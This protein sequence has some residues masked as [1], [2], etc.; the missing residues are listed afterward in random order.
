V[1]CTC[2]HVSLH[3]STVFSTPRHEHCRYITRNKK[4]NGR[5]ELTRTVGCTK[6]EPMDSRSTC[7]DVSHRVRSMSS[8][9][10]FSVF[11][12]RSIATNINHKS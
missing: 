11:A 9:Y 6:S 2:V 12:S 10:E 1:Y 4:S 5:M 3:M 8:L 7:C